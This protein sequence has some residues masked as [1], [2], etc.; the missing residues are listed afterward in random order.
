[1][2][3]ALEATHRLVTHARDLFI[4]HEDQRKQQSKT[5]YISLHVRT[6]NREVSEIE[7]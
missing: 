7:S 4:L 3:P 5:L 1:M 6:I 2:S